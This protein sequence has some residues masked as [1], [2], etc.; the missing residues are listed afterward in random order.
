MDLSLLREPF[1]RVLRQTLEHLILRSSISVSHQFEREFDVV[2]VGGGGAGLAAAIEASNEGA[3]VALLEKNPILGGSTGWSVGSFSAAGT[4]FQHQAGYFEDSPDLHFED[5]AKFAGDLV[6]RDN[7]TLRR[8]LVN[9]SPDTL[10]WLMAHGV[11][12]MGPALEPP[13]RFPRMH[14]VVPGSKSFLYHL[15]RQCRKLGVQILTSAHVTSLVQHND[16][17]TGVMA[18]LGG[19]DAYLFRAHR[20]VVLTTGDFSADPVLKQR[21]ATPVAAQAAAV[22]E[23]NT[24]DGQHMGLSL[25]GRVVNGDIVHGPIMRFVPPATPALPARLPPYTWLA[26]LAVWMM[27]RLPAVLTRPVLM[28]FITTA[29]GPD[30]GLFRAGAIL[31]NRRGDRFSD[32]LDKPALALT[33]Q[34]NGEG[35]IVL[36]SEMARQFQKWPHFISTAPNVAHAYLNDYRSSRRDVFHEAASLEILARLTGME[37]DRLCAAAAQGGANGQPLGE[38]PYV[39]LGPVRSYM[40]LTEGGLAVS[41]QHEVLGQDDRPIAGLYAAGS[42]GQGG[43]LLFGHGHHLGWAFV[44][45]RRAGRFAAGQRAS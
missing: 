24:G 5:L 37:P 10:R 20:A 45:G 25:K 35:Y 36:D 16:R 13:H 31:V 34:P 11:V 8:I 1:G 21:F 27:H 19:G 18:E 12:F 29:L 7:L 6:Q 38:G 41:A 23:T 28:K 33:H 15:S 44:S 4:E 30:A 39:A 3:T 42:A 26:K 40:V 43:L 32:E 9:E 17:V 22:N 14:N 2:V